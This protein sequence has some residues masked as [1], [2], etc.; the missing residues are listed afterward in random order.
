[1]FDG[2][3][4]LGSAFNHFAPHNIINSLING[5]ARSPIF[6]QS[7]FMGYSGGYH[8]RISF[9][10]IEK[11]VTFSDIDMPETYRSQM[12]ARD[13]AEFTIYNKTDHPK[14][15]YIEFYQDWC[16][17]VDYKGNR[18]RCE[19]GGGHPQAAPP[20]VVVIPPGGAQE[21]EFWYSTPPAPRDNPEY[22]DVLYMR[23]VIQITDE[24]GKRA[25]LTKRTKAHRQE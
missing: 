2:L 19:Y 9:N 22:G 10:E 21:I 20:R 18:A 7:A 23:I 17:V 4:M 5:G 15:F 24:K 25:K 6:D 13:R 12:D 14:R 1:M 16:E 3:E 8:P 11:G